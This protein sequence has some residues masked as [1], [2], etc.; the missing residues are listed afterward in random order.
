MNSFFDSKKGLLV[1][2]LILG[3]LAAVLAATGNPGNMAICAACFIRDTVGALGLHTAAKLQYIRPEI[4]GFILGAFI[5]ALATKEFRATIGSKPII[6]FILGF[7]M[8]IGCLVFLG[9]PLRMV[10]RLSAGDLNAVVGL[11]GFLLGVGTGCFFLK[12]GFSLGRAKNINQAAGYTF[13]AIAVILLILAFTGIAYASTEGPGSMHAPLIVALTVGLIFGALAQRSRLCFGG[14]FRDVMLLKDWHLFSIVG[15]LFIIMLIYNIA[16]DGFHLSFAD[17][18]IAHSAHIWN[19][20]GMYAVGLSVV[21]ASG[22]PLR[23]MVMSGQ[24]NLDA[25]ITF[26][27]LAAGAAFCHRFGWAASTYSIDDAGNFVQGGVTTAGAVALLVGIAVLLV[28]GFAYSRKK[29]VAK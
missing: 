4:I 11:V 28:I 15:G 23:Q 5:I 24:G 22:C 14:A 25:G 20:L 19:L 9:C 6:R 27:G 21:L 17:Q 29:T 1:I 18:P 12:K 26:L 13:P 8:M 2:G 3:G 16:T 7:I 10:I